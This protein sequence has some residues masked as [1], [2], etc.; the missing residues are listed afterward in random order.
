M[1][2]EQAFTVLQH[3]FCFG[4]TT[5]IQGKDSERLLY[6]YMVR[7]ALC[8]KKIIVYMKEKLQSYIRPLD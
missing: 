7:L 2:G 3:F 1:R 4:Q 8:K 5:A 6:T